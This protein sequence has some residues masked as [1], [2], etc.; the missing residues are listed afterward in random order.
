VQGVD[1]QQGEGRSPTVHSGN[2]SQCRAQYRYASDLASK[3]AGP[4]VDGSTMTTREIMSVQRQNR[5]PESPS[6]SAF[7]HELEGR[8]EAG[9]VVWY[10]SR[11]LTD[12]SVP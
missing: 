9:G 10:V 4:D 11:L 8:G 3:Q 5:A 12:P 7:R 1:G 2:Q 6:S